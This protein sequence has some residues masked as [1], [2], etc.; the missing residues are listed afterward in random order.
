MVTLGFTSDSREVIYQATIIDESR[1]SRVTING[2]GIDTF[3]WKLGDLVPMIKAVDIYTGATRLILDGAYE[4]YFTDDESYLYYTDF[5]DRHLHRK[6]MESG[7]TEVVLG[8]TCTL[9]DVNSDGSEL[10]ILRGDFG[11]EIFDPATEEST[12][13][14]SAYSFSAEF[15]YDEK[16][17]IYGIPA[18]NKYNR[19]DGTKVAVVN[20]SGVFSSY[21]GSLS[22][23]GSYLCY[24]LKMNNTGSWMKLYMLDLNADDRSNITAVDEAIPSDFAMNGN[25]PNPFN[26]DTMIEFS[27]QSA[28]N[29]TLT[30]YNMAGQRVRELVSDAY[31]TPGIHRVLWNGLDSKGAPVSSGVYISH[32]SSGGMTATGRMMLMK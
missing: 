3:G 9:F 30:I 6:N 12:V 4:A 27:L 16:Q 17:I 21:N 31:M 26:P 18:V 25:Y 22:P 29:V 2:D 23:D 5:P 14:T 20:A 13:I 7:E 32:L 28:G 8:K 10:L 1:G 11:L 24:T 19:Q 15:S